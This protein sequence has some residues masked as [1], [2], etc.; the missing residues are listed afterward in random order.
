MGRFTESQESVAIGAPMLEGD[1]RVAI[2]HHGNFNRWKIHSSTEA[3]QRGVR[4]C[5]CLFDWPT[6]NHA[7]LPWDETLQGSFP[8][9]EFGAA[10]VTGDL[11]CDGFD[12]LIVG[13][14]GAD[15][16]AMN[17]P[18]VIDAGAV[19]VY[20]NAPGPLGGSPPTILRQGTPEVGGEA[21]AGDRFGSVLA[22]GN[23]NGARRLHSKRSC[24]DLVVGT[25]NEDDGIGQIQVFEGGPD[26]LVFGGPI[27]TLD[28]IIDAA[29]DPGD[30]FG[31]SLLAADLNRDGFDDLVIGAPWDAVG[32]SI[33]LI[34]GSEDG[35]VL[36]FATW[37][38][39][40]EGVAGDNVAGDEFGYA[41]TAT[42]AAQ[43][44]LVST[45]ILLA[46]GAPGEN[47]DVGQINLYRVDGIDT[48]ILWGDTGLS[49]SAIQG[50]L[51][52][53]DR[54]GSTLLQPRAM[55]D[56]PFK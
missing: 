18:K 3:M 39:Q 48:L 23:F 25:P 31:F 14:P 37:F 36:E 16:P 10:M 34:P 7:C 54:F 32:G 43:S 24:F 4:E 53:G 1:G 33:T 51:Q 20:F 5:Q 42:R 46:V 9:E 21:E 35:L 22:V 49:Q 29:G 52:A 6:G 56:H 41:L 55:P 40:G 27:I 50:D 45:F 11:D 15:L 26:G 44:L 2:L 47:N 19:Y 38:R 28:D 8:D 17:P 30:R 12:D 13:A